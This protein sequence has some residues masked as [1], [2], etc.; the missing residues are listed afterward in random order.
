MHSNM[1]P[2]VKAADDQSMMH[3][4]V[5]STASLLT[6]LYCVFQFKKTDLNFNVVFNQVLCCAQQLIAMMLL[7]DAMTGLP[8]MH[9]RLS[10]SLID[11]CN[12]ATSLAYEASAGEVEA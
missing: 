7:V 9:V 11:H 2:N 4:I 1:C 6:P 10:C 5:A 3:A 12:I 8:Q